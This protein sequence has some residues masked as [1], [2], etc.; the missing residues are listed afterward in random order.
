M[1]SFITL[2]LLFYNLYFFRLGIIYEFGKGGV[3]V[4]LVQAMHWFQKA[5]AQE[6]QNAIDAVER[7]SQPAKE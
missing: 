6:Y 5:A 3:E 2:Y 1:T 7:L 4:D